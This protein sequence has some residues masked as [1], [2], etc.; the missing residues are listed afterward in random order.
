MCANEKENQ[1]RRTTYHPNGLPIIAMWTAKHGN[2]AFCAL[3]SADCGPAF[4]MDMGKAGAARFVKP[5]TTVD[6][7][8]FSLEEC[9]IFT[10]GHVYVMEGVTPWVRTQGAQPA[11]DMLLASSLRAATEEKLLGLTERLERCLESMNSP[12]SPAHRTKGAGWLLWRAAMLGFGAWLGAH[13]LL[14]SM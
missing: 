11:K 8:G 4:Y 12:L 14:K 10:L 5:E 3:T 13:I 1:E 9:R 6:L 7:T 2:G